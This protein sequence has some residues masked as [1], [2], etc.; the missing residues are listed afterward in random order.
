MAVTTK[1]QLAAASRKGRLAYLSKATTT[2]FQNWALSSTWLTGGNPPAGAAPTTAVIC[3]KDLQGSIFIPQATGSDKNFIEQ[4]VATVVSQVVNVV[5]LDRLGHMGGLSANIT[6]SQ[7]VGLDIS[8]SGSNLTA[9]RGKA[10]YSDVNWYIDCFANTGSTPT[11]ITVNYTKHDDTTGSVDIVTT[12]IQQPGRMTLI[13]DAEGKGIKS[14]QSL[15]LTPATGS[16]GNLGITAVRELCSV[17]LEGVGVQTA[18]QALAVGLPCIENEA[19]A[20][21]AL[22]AASTATGALNVRFKLATG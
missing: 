3:D 19:C 11:T 8:G 6:T 12:G 20:F 21:V 14:V 13:A 15:S 2:A 7:T 17:H 4:V 16:A 22:M 18:N 10:D 5:L 9:R 1:A